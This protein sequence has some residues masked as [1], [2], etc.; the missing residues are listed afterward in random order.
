MI[1]ELSTVD[2]AG[3]PLSTRCLD[4]WILEF[5]IDHIISYTEIKPRG[6]PLKL[7]G[8]AEFKNNNTP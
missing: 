4:V 5:S 2:S 1:L 7:V 8:G 6:S 3:E